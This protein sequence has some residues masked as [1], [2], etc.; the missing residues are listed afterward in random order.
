MECTQI[1]SGSSPLQYG[2]A[3]HFA[4]ANPKGPGQDDLGRLLRSLADEIGIR[5]KLDVLYIAYS[6]EINK[7]GYWPSFVVF[8]NEATSEEGHLPQLSS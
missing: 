3:R 5:G 4:L 2:T 6:M 7:H 8:Y 1:V